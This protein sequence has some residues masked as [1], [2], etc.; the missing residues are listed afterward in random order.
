MS[1]REFVAQLVIILP[2]G[3]Q[4]EKPFSDQRRA[5]G[6]LGMEL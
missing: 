2:H 3:S 4:E 6:L 1:D 5:S